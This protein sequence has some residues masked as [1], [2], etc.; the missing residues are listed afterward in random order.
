MVTMKPV[1]YSP[2]K[3]Y[4]HTRDVGN[5]S[6]FRFGGSVYFS[7][8]IWAYHMCGLWAHWHYSCHN[9]WSTR[10]CIQTPLLVCANPQV[11]QQKLSRRYIMEHTLNVPQFK[12]YLILGWLKF[13]YSIKSFEDVTVSCDQMHKFDVCVQ[14]STSMDRWKV[15]GPWVKVDG[16]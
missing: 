9:R 4:H 1:E 13:L 2:K 5:D 3:S 6:W 14:N 12:I 16:A 7:L 8:A 15:Y 10:H 11:T